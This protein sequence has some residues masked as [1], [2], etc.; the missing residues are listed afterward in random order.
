MQGRRA[1]FDRFAVIFSIAIV[2]AYAEILTAAGAY[3]NRPPSTQFSCRTDRSGLIRAA[4]WYAFLYLLKSEEKMNSPS[5]GIETKECK[6]LHVKYDFRTLFFTK[7]VLA[8]R[9][10]STFNSFSCR[11]FSPECY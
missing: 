4:S 1:I 11:F 2:W 8:N 5:S 6:K 7:L 9:Y 10:R 3:K